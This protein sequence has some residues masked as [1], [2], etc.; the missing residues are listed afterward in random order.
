M[1]S[2]FELVV[3][4]LQIP[5]LFGD[6]LLLLQN[7]F[8]NLQDLVVLLADLFDTLLVG[9]VVMMIDVVV[10]RSGVARADGSRKDGCGPDGGWKRYDSI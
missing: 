4:Q 10:D 9:T 3:G 1:D 6:L 5:N 8:L 2:C 7:I